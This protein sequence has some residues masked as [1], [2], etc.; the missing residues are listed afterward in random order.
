LEIGVL[1][2]DGDVAELI[3]ALRH[4]STLAQAIALITRFAKDLAIPY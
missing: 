2:C 3:K 1:T 4:L